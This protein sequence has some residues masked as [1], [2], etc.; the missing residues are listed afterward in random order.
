MAGPTDGD[1]VYCRA[2]GG[3]RCR[4]TVF[5]QNT[6]L[7]R[8]VDDV[9]PVTVLQHLPAKESACIYNKGAKMIDSKHVQEE[10]PMSDM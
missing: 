7:N 8:V 2:I 6:G 10:D 3:N 1:A 5:L 9:F 4:L